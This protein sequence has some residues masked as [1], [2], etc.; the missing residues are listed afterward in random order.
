VQRQQRSHARACQQK[1]RQ[2]R[3]GTRASLGIA[4]VELPA[5]C[6]VS[7]FPLAAAVSSNALRRAGRSPAGEMCARWSWRGRA[8]Q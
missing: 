5:A 7:V 3:T 6:D 4:P 1:R 2:Q 8:A